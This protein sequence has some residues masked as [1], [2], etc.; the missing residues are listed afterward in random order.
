MTVNL[1]LAKSQCRVTGSAEDALI[2]KYLAAAIGWVE[3]HTSKKLTAATAI[4]ERFTAFPGEPYAFALTWGP[5]VTDVEVAY[6]D[7]AGADQT[8]TT[9]RLIDGKLYPATNTSWPAIEAGSE[10]ILTY[11]AGFTAV[12]D[13]LDMAVLLLVGEYFDNRATG[14][15][16]PAAD[17][18]VRNLCRAFRQ[19]VLR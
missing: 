15:V 18:A 3:N 16:S 8:I 13:Q 12:P 5:N 19:P 9:G 1:A 17:L 11:K 14:E 7:A 2:G 6:V 4:E 10:V